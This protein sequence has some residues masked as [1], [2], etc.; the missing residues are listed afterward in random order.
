MNL[1]KL[2]LSMIGTL[3]L[4]IGISTAFF[5]FLLDLAGV[6]F[7]YLPFMVVAINI[8]QWLIAPYLIDAMYRVRE[9]PKTEDPWLHKTVERLSNASGIEK[10]KVMLARIPIPNAFA[11][12]SPIAGKRVA[13]TTG[14]MNKLEEEEI[15]AVL[16]HEIGHLKHRD[17][18]IMMFVSVLPAIFYYIGYS[19]MMSAYYSSAYRSRDSRQG[20]GGLAVLIGGLSMVLYFVLTLFSLHLS[21][22]REYYADSHSVSIVPDGRRKLSEALAKIVATTSGMRKQDFGN[23][24]SFRTLFISDPETALSDSARLQYGV[25]DQQMVERIL[26]QKLT[27]AD[28]LA[29]IFS[30]HPN[31]IKRLRA[32][33][34]P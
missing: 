14:L 8:V 1:V 18:Q 21:R 20:N 11:Y 7:L 32:L 13:V 34:A 25:S 33:Q 3:A 10:P 15:E 29:E 2:R 9:V 6:S 26:S 16:G 5:A 28:R 19:L 31:I 24:S 17:V 30:T 22:L 27:W 23:A 12:G 4:I